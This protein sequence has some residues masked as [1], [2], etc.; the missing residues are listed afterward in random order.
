MTFTSIWELKCYFTPDL[1]MREYK[2]SLSAGNI[3]KLMANESVQNMCGVI[4]NFRVY[5]D[6]LTDEEIME[7]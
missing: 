2:N 6:E 4:N 5:S 3:G 7:L 1:A